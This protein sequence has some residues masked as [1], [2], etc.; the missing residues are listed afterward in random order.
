MGRCWHERHTSACARLPDC[1][2]VQ[3]NQI[4]SGAVLLAEVTGV[5]LDA[6]AVRTA[7]ARS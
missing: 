7:M 6:L 4:T 3:A 1:G 2:T 5:E